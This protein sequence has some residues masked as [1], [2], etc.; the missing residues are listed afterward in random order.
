MRQLLAIILITTSLGVTAISSTSEPLLAAM[1][2]G[3]HVLLLRHALAPGFGDPPE[4]TIG[5]C[6]T[7]RN[8]SAE[9]RQQARQLG[10]TLRDA[11]LDDLVVYSS[12]WC[13][14]WDTAIEMNIGTPTTHMGLNSFF[15]NR[16]QQDAIVNEL[17]ALLASLEGGPS[18]VLVTHAVNVRAITGQ[19]VGSGQGILLRLEPNGEHTVIGRL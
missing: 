7:Q 5:D 19:S 1:Q 9:G 11:G 14:C 3:S 8:L 4:F 13:R 12:Q 16:S 6:S 17:Q 15:Q 18:A 10:Q 2:K